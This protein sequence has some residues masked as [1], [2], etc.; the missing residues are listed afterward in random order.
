MNSFKLKPFMVFTG[1]NN[2]DTKH[3]LNKLKDYDIVIENLGGN[4]HPEFQVEYLYS[5]VKLFNE[6]HHNIR[7][8]FSTHSPYI[9]SALNCC[10]IAYE[11]YTKKNFKEVSEIFDN[12]KW[13]SPDRLGVYN[14][15]GN[16]VKSII[17]TETNLI[18]ADVIDN[19][20][21]KIGELFDNLL[22]LS[23]KK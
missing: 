10:L 5:L 15:T 19:V 11:A 8:A 7:I 6:T 12:T 4:L 1:K 21:E 16:E 3:I 23:Y 20:S 13:I 14:I 22:E 9:L 18:L 2:E 17:D